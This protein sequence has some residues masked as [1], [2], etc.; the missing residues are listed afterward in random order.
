M[1]N[2]LPFLVIVAFF[3]VVKAQNSY[4]FYDTCATGQLLYFQ[5]VSNNYVAVVD[6]GECDHDRLVGYMEIP[7]EVVFD[8]IS[9]TVTFIGVNA[10]HGGNGLTSV[11]IPNSV[12]TTGN[13]AFEGCSGLTSLTIPSS[14]TTVGNGAFGGCSGLT[15]VTFESTTP[16]SLNGCLRSTFPA[17]DTV[18]V[19]SGSAANYK[20]F[21]GPYSNINFVSGSSVKEHGSYDIDVY[22]NPTSA[23]VNV[24]FET[25]EQYVRNTKIHLHDIYGHLLQIVSVTSE[26]TLV[27][28]SRYAAG[29]YFV[30]VLHDGNTLKTSKVVRN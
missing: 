19:T 16:P 9:Y 6:G 1:K 3:I 4:D 14:V 10:F 17:L 21:F 7:F 11:I 15:T 25:G 20:T 12:T 13:S 18:Y 29:V 22:P 5:I 8:G 2:F 24:V 30:K 28:L 26:K 23:I 27:D